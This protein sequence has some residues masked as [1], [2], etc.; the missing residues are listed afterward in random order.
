MTIH[1]I[2]ERLSYCRTRRPADIAYITLL[3]LVCDASGW[4]YRPVAKLWG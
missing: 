3:V 4:Y 1:Q 2:Y